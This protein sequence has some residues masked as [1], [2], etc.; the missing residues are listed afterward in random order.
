[1][2]SNFF[3]IATPP[4]AFSDYQIFKILI[5]KFLVNFYNFKFGLQ[6]RSYLGQ[7]AFYTVSQKNAPTLA[8]CSL[9]KHGLILIIF[10]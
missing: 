7:K 8:S 6:Q 1:M 9:D 4:T 5:V 10:S 3:Q 2:S